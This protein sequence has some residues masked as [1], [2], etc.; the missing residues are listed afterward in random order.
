[1]QSFAV[2][3][4]DDRQKPPIEF[5]IDGV[6]EPGVT[7]PD[8]ATTWHEEF[9]APTHVPFKLMRW[10]QSLR[11]ADGRVNLNALLSFMG[12][13][14]L[15]ESAERFTAMVNDNT[16]IV[17]VAVLAK[18][19]EWIVSHYTSVDPTGAPSSSTSGGASIEAGSTDGS[20]LS[21]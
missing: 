9:A 6:Y 14:L 8:G 3:T 20:P 17:H 5:A 4:D 18:A 7:G 16:R 1:M 11:L 15:P 19:M 10:V 13:V 21:A 12:D 2:S